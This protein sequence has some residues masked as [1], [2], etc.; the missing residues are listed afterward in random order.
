MRV[1]ILCGLPGVGKLTIAGG[2]ARAYG[3]RVFHNHL[4]FD[5]V[6][7]L[8]SFGT[9][10]FV[11]LRE[12]L[13]VELLCRAVEERVGNIIFTV[14]RDRAVDAAFPGKLV[15]ELSRL[16]AEVCCVEVTCNDEDLEHRI[17]SAE[18]GKFGKIQSVSRLRELRAAG[19]FP[20]FALPPSALTVDTSGLSI[21]QAVALVAVKL[22]HA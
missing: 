12:R 5:A 3:Y 16:G 22:N 6:E 13:W 14:A 1:V 21:P 8:F 10:P 4:V 19:A 17:T 20:P 15:A 11:E 18:R 2:L 9:P 7:A